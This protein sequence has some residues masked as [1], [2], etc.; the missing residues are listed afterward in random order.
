[1]YTLVR[2]EEKMRALMNKRWKMEENEKLLVDGR[3]QRPYCDGWNTKKEM[4]ISEEHKLI[5]LRFRIFEPFAIRL[6]L[7]VMKSRQ[8]NYN[9]G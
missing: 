2:C 5:N 8:W 1:V 7:T 6:D 3:N 4:K 9:C